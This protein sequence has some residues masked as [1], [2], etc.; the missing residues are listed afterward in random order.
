MGRPVWA[1]VCFCMSSCRSLTKEDNILSHLPDTTFKPALVC[2]CLS[3]SMC[4]PARA[5]TDGDNILSDPCSTLLTRLCVRLKLH[6]ET[7][8]NIKFKVLVWVSWWQ[9]RAFKHITCGGICVREREWGKKR[10]QQQEK[11]SE[12]E[13]GRINPVNFMYWLG[14]SRTYTPAQQNSFL[15]DFLKARAKSVQTE[16]RIREASWG[17]SCCST[18][19]SSVSLG[20]MQRILGGMRFI[21]SPNELHKIREVC[22]PHKNVLHADGKGTNKN[23]LLSAICVCSPVCKVSPVFCLKVAWIAAQ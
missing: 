20:R 5:L 16:E 19:L 15:F 4:Q 1:G 12:R 9:E 11:A 18:L 8:I 21:L 7:C 6:S 22:L 10:E 17:N 14:G 3:E 23:Y 13:T 2:V